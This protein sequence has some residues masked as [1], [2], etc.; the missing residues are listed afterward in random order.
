M[1]MVSKSLTTGDGLQVAHHHMSVDEAQPRML[2]G[3]W[4]SADDFEAEQLPQLRRP[5]VGG[6]NEIELH[7]A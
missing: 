3:R 7:G 5:L 2:E 4:Q 6:D 1:I